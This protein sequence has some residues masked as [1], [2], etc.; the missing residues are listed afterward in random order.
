VQGEQ[1]NTAGVYSVAAT[2]P[3]LTDGI[4][5]DFVNSHI[6]F[7][8]SGTAGLNTLITNGTDIVALY[9]KVARG[10][11]VLNGPDNDY[12]GRS[13][14]GGGG[15]QE[16]NMYNFLIN[17]LQWAADCPL[18]ADV[19][20]A[21][22]VTIAPDG[23][24]LTGYLQSLQLTAAAFDAVGNPVPGTTFTWESSNP[25]LVQ[26]DATGLVTAVAGNGSVT[27]TATA[28]G[29]ATPSDVATVLVNQPAATIEVTPAGAGIS[30]GTQAFT[31]IARNSNGDIL[32]NKVFGWASM[33]TAVASVNFSSGVATAN[34]SGQVAIR[35]AVDG[36]TAFG[37]LS[38]SLAPSVAVNA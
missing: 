27:I 30:G 37:L 5:G 6:R 23:A 14:G 13:A 29:G 35:A 2:V 19:G 18:T 38:V 26:V 32:T 34:A 31:A 10:C 36:R 17:S 1:F 22:A 9:G 12:H 21:A 3:G 24:T 28:V 15:A 25:A 16:V 4:T 33:N 20:P 7:Q 11:I 8:L